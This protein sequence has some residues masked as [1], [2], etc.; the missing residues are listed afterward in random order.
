MIIYYIKVSTFSE[1]GPVLIVSQHCLRI[2]LKGRAPLRRTAV[3]ELY[4]NDP[5]KLPH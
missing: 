4:R 1:E 2:T 5:E 3:L